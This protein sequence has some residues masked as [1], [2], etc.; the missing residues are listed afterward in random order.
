MTYYLVQ[1][2][3]G[4][5]IKVALARHESSEVI[6]LNTAT[7]VLKVR[8]EKASTNAF[9]VTGVKD[10]VRDN[11]AIFSLGTNMIDIPPGRY[12]GEVEVTFDDTSIE[13]IYEL[14]PLY[15]REDL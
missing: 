15:I 12:N 11:E 3:T 10:D 2:D 13:T 7:A 4:T 8:K 14:L 6:D 5:Q 1:G 9:E